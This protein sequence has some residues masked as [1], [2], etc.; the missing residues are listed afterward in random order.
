MK[1]LNTKKIVDLCLIAMGIGFIAGVVIG[2]NVY[3]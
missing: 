3:F 1:N 2:I